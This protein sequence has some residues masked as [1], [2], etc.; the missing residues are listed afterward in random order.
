MNK[1]SI[2][3]LFN[4][5]RV[6]LAGDGLII[7]S[8]KVNLSSLTVC[9]ALNLENGF[10]LFLKSYQI[11]ASPFASPDGI[12]FLNSSEKSSRIVQSETHIVDSR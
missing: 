5:L 8:S 3:I 1:Q 2:N 12:F 4:G 10:P 6:H 9:S 11:Q 7:S